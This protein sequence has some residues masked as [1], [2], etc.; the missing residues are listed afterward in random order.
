M[1]LLLDLGKV[2]WK[3]LERVHC[4]RCH[5]E[6][7]LL[8]GRGQNISINR[9]LEEVDSNLDGWL[10]GVPDLVEKVTVHVVEIAR[11][12]KLEV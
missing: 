3:S 7:S 12:L 9:G 5:W 4:S 6:H 2:D 10:W 8:T 1:T 11:E